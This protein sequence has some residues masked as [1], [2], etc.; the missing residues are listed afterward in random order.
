MNYS[1]HLRDEIIKLLE[2]LAKKRGLPSPAGEGEPIKPRFDKVTVEPP[3]DPSHGDV[4]SNAAMVV[5]SQVGM[6]PREL[7]G[8]LAAS[9]EGHEAVAAVEVAGPGFLNMEL[10]ASFWHA[11]LKEVL[12]A[13]TDYGRSDI[14]AGEKVNVEYVSANPTGP[15]HV[16]H[17]RGAVIGD[18]L[19]SLL[20]WVGFDVTREYYVND[21]G[22]QVD[23]L[24]KSNYLRLRKQKGEDVDETEFEG[25]YPGPYVESSA[26]SM[27]PEFKDKLD[28]D[29]QV[30]LPRIRARAI[31]Y[32][33]ALI[34][35]DLEALGTRH[36]VFTSEREL[37]RSGAVEEALR[38]LEARG[39]IYTGVLEAPKGGAPGDW[40]PRPQTLFRA[41]EF[42]DDVDRPLRKSDGSWTYFATDIANHL[43]KFRRGSR[44]MINVWGADHGGYVKRMQAAVKAVTDGK[45]TLD[46]KLCQMVNLLN[47]GEPVKMSKR[48]GTYVTLS[49]VIN[50]VGKDVV[51]FIMLTRRNDAPLEFDLARVTEQSRENPVFYVQYAHARARSVMRHAGAEF[52]DMRL[53]P[54]ALSRAELE[55]LTDQAELALI[56]M[57]AGWPQVVENAANAHEPHR[58]AFYLYDVAAAFHGLWNKG[59]EDRDLRFIVGDN[60]RLTAARLALVQG[61]ACVIA[62]G[63]RIFGVEPVEELR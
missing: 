34:R 30:L 2:A 37:V 18:V 56:R 19:A 46:V 7:G 38:T 33:M 45:G 47:R 61:V 13:G 22:A 17:G 27:F 10:K 16:G 12:T 25:L 44:T 1:K 3:R 52:P 6:K 26:K 53:T 59:K 39:L 40:E 15:L 58:L 32:M 20:E 9:L 5:A 29:I 14:G 24:A 36:D 35:E 49:E 23:D 4:S 41:T 54:E 50:Q 55:R 42:G 48:A 43:D 28:T 11:R 60:D 57:L 21:S 8:M 63:L 51:R 62:S 31:D